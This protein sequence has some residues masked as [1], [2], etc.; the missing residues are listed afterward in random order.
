MVCVRAAFV[1]AINM[2]SFRV[3]SFKERHFTGLSFLRRFSTMLMS[4]VFAYFV[5]GGFRL[6]TPLINLTTSGCIC[7]APQYCN[8]LEIYVWHCFLLPTRHDDMSQ[9]ILVACVEMPLFLYI[10][11]TLGHA[12]ITNF[13]IKGWR[14]SML[15]GKQVLSEEWE[16]F[17]LWA[18]SESQTNF[19][20]STMVRSL[21]HL[22][23]ITCCYFLLCSDIG[24]WKGEIYNNMNIFPNLKW[25][26]QHMWQLG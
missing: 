6:D 2:T 20:L 21:R 24:D 12:I 16:F 11:L 9:R 1:I 19:V 4:Q 8:N 14:V 7:S 17:L 5:L 10:V 15:K 3:R 22:R 25:K 26:Y 18:S 23:R 13:P